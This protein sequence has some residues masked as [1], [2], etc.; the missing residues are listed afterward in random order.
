[1][2]GTEEKTTFWVKHRERSKKPWDEARDMR[3]KKRLTDKTSTRLEMD[4]VRCIRALLAG[5]GPLC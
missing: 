4:I 5:T 1:M 3:D 2:V